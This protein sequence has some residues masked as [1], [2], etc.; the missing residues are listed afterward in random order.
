MC[1]SRNLVIIIIF[2]ITFDL[3]IERWGGG[4]GPESNCKIVGIFPFF[5]EMAAYKITNL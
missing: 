5:D 3:S 2:K 1:I 4:G